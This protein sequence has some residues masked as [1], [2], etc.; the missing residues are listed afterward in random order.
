MANPATPEEAKVDGDRAVSVETGSV[1]IHEV[2]QG[3]VDLVEHAV[4]FQQRMELLQ[5]SK[6]KVMGLFEASLN[7]ESRAVFWQVGGADRDGD[8]KL[9]VK[10]MLQA[11]GQGGVKKARVELDS[12]WQRDGE[13]PAVFAARLGAAALKYSFRTGKTLSDTEMVE[14]LLARLKHGGRVEPLLVEGK[15]TVEEIVRLATVFDTTE[16]KPKRVER[17]PPAVPAKTDEVKDKFVKAQQRPEKERCS[18]CGRVG[19]GDATC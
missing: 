7:Q 15:I 11:Q 17:R 14:R 18:Y 12:V 5:V 19:H 13:S 9:I 16:H 3:S 10:K 4:Q 6:T 1:K 2:K 8:I